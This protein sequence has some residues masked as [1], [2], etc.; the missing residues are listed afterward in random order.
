MFGCLIYFDIVIYFLTDKVTLSRYFVEQQFLSARI[1][2][3]TPILKRTSGWNNV[4]R[5]MYICKVFLEFFF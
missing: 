5:Y 3:H 2:I 4:Y 1:L